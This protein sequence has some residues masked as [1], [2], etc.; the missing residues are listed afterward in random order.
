M[1]IQKR[2]NEIVEEYR[3][4]EKPWDAFKLT[5][6]KG[7]LGEKFAEWVSNQRDGGIDLPSALAFAK[8]SWPASRIAELNWGLSAPRL[9][10]L[11]EWWGVDLDQ[12]QPVG[13][14]AEPLQYDEQIRGWALIR[15][16]GHFFGAEI[17][18]LGIFE[19][20]AT[21]SAYVSDNFE[22]GF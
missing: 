1:D 11:I 21:L 10:E 20:E 8:I 4:A 2:A 13:L 17:D 15:H 7:Y 3:S 14:I 9:D 12:G 6:P 22:G 18:L 16:S 19:D 5:F